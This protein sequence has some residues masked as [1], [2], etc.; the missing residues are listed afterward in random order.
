M[1][2]PPL[3]SWFGWAVS[4]NVSELEELIDTHTAQPDKWLFWESFELNWK[5]QSQSHMLV[6]W[7][8]LK[9]KRIIKTPKSKFTELSS[10]INKWL[11]ISNH[12]LESV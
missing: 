10:P 7:I 5:T 1:I 6:V 3:K 4:S 11:S 9:N 2:V 8:S 12:F